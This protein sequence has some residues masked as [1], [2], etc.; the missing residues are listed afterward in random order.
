MMGSMGGGIFGFGQRSSESNKNPEGEG[1]NFGKWDGSASFVHASLG[2]YPNRMRVIHSLVGLL[3]C[4]FL[5]LACQ[6]DYQGSAPFPQIQDTTFLEV[7]NWYFLGQDPIELGSAL[8]FPFSYQIFEEEFDGYLLST[9]TRIY[10][11][12][13]GQ[14]LSQRR[15]LLDTESQPGDTLNKRSPLQY[16]LLIDKQRSNS[17]NSEVF[18]ILRRS[19]IGIKTQRER[20]LW[21]ISPQ[22]GILAVA[23]YDIDPL[24]GQVT[25]DMLGDY[26]YFRGEELIDLIKY[27]DN[28]VTWL[29]DREREIIYE[30]HKL[31]STLKSRNFKQGEDLFEYRFN[32]TSTQDWVDFRL[33][34]EGD[35]IRLTAGDSC[36][37]FSEQ[38]ELIRSSTCQ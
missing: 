34:L 38:L 7:D 10:Q 14:D 16:H 25:M 20:S 8:A 32:Q 22:E 30:F 13:A 23:K 28:H 5:L 17:G 12:S 37:F 24:V 26:A 27:Y 1:R 19:R 3:C 15:L 36:F 9:P 33:K 11:L 31:R 2:K 4:L 6:E 29:I 35:Q 21:V 18:F